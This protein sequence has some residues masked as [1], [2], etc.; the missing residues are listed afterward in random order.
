VARPPYLSP[1]TYPVV[2]PPTHVAMVVASHHHGRGLGDDTRL[3]SPQI[4]WQHEE[5]FASTAMPLNRR[6]LTVRWTASG[7][8]HIVLDT[9]GLDLS[10]MMPYFRHKIVRIDLLAVHVGP[11]GA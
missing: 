6:N 2:S 9:P 10:W 11:L 7:I 3:A 5:R 4:D 1:G 8:G